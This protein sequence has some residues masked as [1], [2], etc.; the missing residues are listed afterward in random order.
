MG[1]CPRLLSALGHYQAQACAES[2]HEFICVLV[3]AMLVRP[4]VFGGFHSLL[5][6]QSFPFLF[7]RFPCAMVGGN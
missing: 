2:V 1:L 7:Y 6:L 5:L 4:R 3:F